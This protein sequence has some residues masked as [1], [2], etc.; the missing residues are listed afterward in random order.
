MNALY[1][2]LDVHKESTYAT[3]IN[4]FGEVQIQKRMKNEEIPEFLEPLQV[5]KVAME[6]STY[7]MPLYRQLTESG[8]DI[9]VSHPKRTK[10]IAES[11]IKNDKVDSKALAELLRLNAL[12]ESYIPPPEVALLRE[13]VRRRAFLVREVS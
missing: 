13:K 11:R 7:I 12:P 5:E 1:C 9:T 3:I 8:Y 4:V 2:G 10:L 6:A